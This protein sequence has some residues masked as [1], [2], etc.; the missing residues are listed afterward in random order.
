ML[1]IK[2]HTNGD[3]LSFPCLMEYIYGDNDK[4]F[5]V[6]MSEQGDDNTLI[7]TVISCDD[8]SYKVGHHSTN[9]AATEF[10]LYGGT[11]EL[12]NVQ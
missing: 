9:W 1:S 3:T 12:E 10:K 2:K 7:G 8:R 4:T 6:L 11:I 5:I